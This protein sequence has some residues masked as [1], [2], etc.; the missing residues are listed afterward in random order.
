MSSIGIIGFGRFGRLTAHYLAKDFSVAVATRSDQRAA[1]DACGARSVPFE[2]ACSQKVVILCMP[3]SAMRDTLCRVAPLLRPGT[4]VMDV[5]SVKVYPVQWMRELLPEG[6]SILPTHPMFGPDS[7]A[8][9]LQG[10]KIVLCPDRIAEDHYDRIRRWLESKGLVVIRTTA[11]EHDE[12]IAVSLSLTHFIGRSLSAFGARDLDIDTE[13]Y[14]RL[15]HIL[16]VV[17]HDTWQLFEDMHTY[18]PY[19]RP[20]RQAFIDAMTGIHERLD[21]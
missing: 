5:C 13:G 16:G 7:A 6:V 18:N 8:D 19:A 12:K 1:I 14:K 20:T 11:E 10:R 17:S 21:G 3:I 9:S 15:M 4:L 2:T